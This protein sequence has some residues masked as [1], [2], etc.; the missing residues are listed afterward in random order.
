MKFND[1]AL[2][3]DITAPGV[4][5][6]AAYSEGVSPTH[7]EFDNR[8]TPF[9]SESG[10]SMS[11]PH[12]SGIVGLIKTLHPNWSPAAIRSAIMTTGNDS[13]IFS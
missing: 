4:N 6:I 13:K 9:N 12:V 7:E 11:C 3:P 5:I 1:S 10:T 8:R 2:Q